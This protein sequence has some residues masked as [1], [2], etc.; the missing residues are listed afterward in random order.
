MKEPKKLNPFD[1]LNGLTKNKLYSEEEVKSVLDVNLLL[2]YIRSNRALLYVAEY[3]NKN[4]HMDIY[5]QYQFVMS[6]IPKQI[7]K[8]SWIKTDKL[9]E[10]E[11]VMLIRR[12]F[13]CGE[14]TAKEY[15]NL[16]DDKA[17]K[18][19]KRLYLSGK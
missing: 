5:S 4:H 17:L 11:E 19:I 16:L 2:K 13:V 1:V 15:L 8:I 3:L 6:V 14:N 10:D 9:V 12:H 18:R 7:T